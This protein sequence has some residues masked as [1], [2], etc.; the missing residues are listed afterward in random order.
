MLPQKQPGIPYWTAFHGY[1]VKF[2]P[3]LKGRLAVATAQNFGIIG[4][5]RHYALQV[6]AHANVWAMLHEV[7]LFL[8]AV[9]GLDLL[10]N[11]HDAPGLGGGGKV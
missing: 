6:T 10:V 8:V 5:G 1:A 4:N 9:E 3:F 7:R 2:S 11:S